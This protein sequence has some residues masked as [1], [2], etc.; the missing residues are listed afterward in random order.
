[1]VSVQLVP[2]LEEIKKELPAPRA[3]AAAAA[4]EG[5]DGDV[6][7]PWLTGAAAGEGRLACSK[8]LGQ[9]SR[10]ASR[11]T[12]CQGAIQCKG[13]SGIQYKIPE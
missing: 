4:V 8:P 2:G 7:L 11:Q 9:Q 6:L 10:A 12:S 5:R 13:W 1:M 3:G